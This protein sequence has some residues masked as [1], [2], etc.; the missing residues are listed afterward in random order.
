MRSPF[1]VRGVAF[2]SLCV[3]RTRAY[4]IRFRIRPSQAPCSVAPLPNPLLAWLC[5]SQRPSGDRR[6]ARKTAAEKLDHDSCRRVRGNLCFAWSGGK[7]RNGTGSFV[8]CKISDPRAWRDGFSVSSVIFSFRFGA[9]VVNGSDWIPLHVHAALWTP[10]ARRFRGLARCLPAPRRN[11]AA[12]ST[13]TRFCGS[14]PATGPSG[15]QAGER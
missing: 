7:E 14:H 15:K 12:E 9:M 1:C 2:S 11:M 8:T 4:R 5:D 10:V 13:A 6:I 3:R